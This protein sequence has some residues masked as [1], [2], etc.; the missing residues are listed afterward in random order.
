MSNR[1]TDLADDDFGPRPVRVDLH[2]HTDASNEADEAVL[3]AI[4][5]PES[6]SR[7]IEV[8]EQARRRGM[9]LVTVTDHDSLAGVA[10]L[11]ERSDVLAGEELTCYF[12]EDRCKIHLLLWGLTPADHDAVQAVAADI[13]AVAAEVERRNLAHAVA[14]ALYRQNDRLELYHLERLVLLF[15]GFETLNGA[16]SALH[17]EHLDPLLDGLTPSA[18]EELATKHGIAARWP[19]PHVK[20][21]TGGSDDHGLFNVGR[22]WTE[23]PSH[24]TTPAAVLDCLRTG[25]CRP[26]GEAGSSLKLAHNFYGVGLRYQ[27]GRSTGGTDTTV[28][29]ALVGD[30]GRRVRRRDVVRSVVSSG[31]RRLGRRLVR[32]FTGRPAEPTGTA[33]LLDLLLKSCVSRIGDHPAIGDALRQG[34]VALAE[35]AAMFDMVSAV[36]RDVAAGVAGSVQR[37]LGR[38]ELAGV[39]DALSTVAAHQALLIPYYFALFQQNRERAVLARVTGRRAGVTASSLRLGV[40]TDTFDEVNGVGRFIRDMSRQGRASGRSLTVCTSTAKPVVDCPSRVNFA[41]LFTRPTPFYADQPISIPP[42]L[43]VMEWADRQQFDAVHIHTPEPM[44]LCGLAV[45]AMLRVPV[46]MTYHTDL[47]R[48]VS[49]LTGGDHRLTAAT[50]AYLRWFHGRADRTFARSKAYRE[51]LRQLGIQD[52]RLATTPPGV[53]TDAFSPQWRDVT[54][55][56]TMGIRQPHRLLYAGRVSVEKN[57]PF[58]TDVFRRLCRSRD[59]VAL[60]IAGDG[61]FRAQMAGELKGLPVHFLG[62][63]DDAQLARLYASADLFVFPSK[64]DTLGQVVLEAQASGLPVLVSDQGGPREITDDGITGRVLPADHPGVWTAAI[65]DLLTDLPGR[66]RM[67]R[68]APHRV[69]RYGLAHTFEGFWHEHVA[70][71]NR[72]AGEGNLVAAS[73]EVERAGRASH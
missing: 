33:L 65:D 15:K 38:G 31:A 66:L 25:L 71:V 2:C 11:A 67:A 24:A 53:D 56:P 22:T 13:Y 60:I 62:W 6:Y 68:T 30:G 10:T 28:M 32:P 46:L 49:D 55:W 23:F 16:H 19:R 1:I 37:S 26:G 35:H 47:P 72:T 59:D 36:N 14:H 58:L 50:E 61:P 73:P 63:Q 34:R 40:F 29:R 64:T 45:A 41:P 20:A 42:L 57:L 4:G 70:A 27:G 44:G 39:F 69:A 18:I 5:C 54:V 21:R 17:R 9:D 7:P 52:T 12:P 8:Y 48:Y 43:E 3:N 51:P